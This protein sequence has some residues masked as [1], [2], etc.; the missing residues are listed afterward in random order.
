MEACIGTYL[1]DVYPSHGPEHHGGALADS[2]CPGLEL[3][4]GKEHLRLKYSSSN[5]AETQKGQRQM[6]RG[7]GGSSRPRVQG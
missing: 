3:P 2:V 7:G 5:R 6:G 4:L 1:H